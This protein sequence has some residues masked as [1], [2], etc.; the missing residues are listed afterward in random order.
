MSRK[1]KISQIAE[2]K[3]ELLFEYLLEEW[4]YKVKSNFVKKLDKNIQIIKNQPESF[5]KSDK[6]DGLRKCVI[7]KQTTLFYEFNDTEIHILTFFDT[8]QDP[9]KLKKDLG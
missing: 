1:I 3:L 5:P 8:R 4:S 9:K 2:E 7:T 6:Q